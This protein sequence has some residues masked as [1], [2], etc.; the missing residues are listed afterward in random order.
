MSTIYMGANSIYYGTET[1]LEGGKDPDC[2]RA[3]P[4]DKLDEN[5]EFTEKI[6]KIL[7]IKKHPAIKNG[8]IEIFSMENILIIERFDDENSLGLAINLGEEKEF[9]I[10]SQI[11]LSNNYQNKKLKENSFVIWES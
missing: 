1:L 5:K 6:K 3:F 4:W 10:T 2:R 11:L 9:E 7:A 8:S